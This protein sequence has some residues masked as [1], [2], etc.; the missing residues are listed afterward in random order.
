MRIDGPRGRIAKRDSTAGRGRQYVNSG[1]GYD[2]GI[3]D[4]TLNEARRNYRR[5]GAGL[6][7][8]WTPCLQSTAGTT[9]MVQ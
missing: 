8:S 9:G 1:Q 5:G 7:S 6:V 2:V 3:K 4:A